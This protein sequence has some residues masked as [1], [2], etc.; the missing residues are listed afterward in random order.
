M[1][2]RILLPILVLALVATEA[3]GAHPARAATAT[4]RPASPPATR[5][6]PGHGLAVR[7]ARPAGESVPAWRPAA[8][9]WPAAGSAQAVAP[10]GS[11]A[12]SGAPAGAAPRSGGSSG[13]AAPAGQRTAVAWPGGLPMTLPVPATAGPVR[14]DV[15]DQRA[16]ARAGITGVLLRLSSVPAGSLSVDYGAFADAVG[17]DWSARLGLV[18]LPD[19]AV[20]TPPAAG[21][22]AATP[23]RSRNDVRT[24]RVTAQTGTTGGVFALTAST[25]GGTGTYGA[26]ALS[27]SSTWQVGQQSG[28]FDWSYPM[29]TVDVPDGDGPGVTLTYSSQSV[30][31]RTAETNNQTSWAGEGFDLVSGYVERRYK[32]C[33]DDGGPS[34]NGDQCWAG[35]NA[36]LVLGSTSTELVRDDATGRWRLKD[37]DGSRVEKLTGATNGD[38]DGEYW[39]VTTTDGTQYTF[40]LNHLPGWV[41][42]KPTTASAWTMP[43]Y[44]NSSGE[45]CSSSAG[46][47][48]SWCMQAWRWNL[49]YTV[50]PHGNATTYTYV[51]ETN[52]YRR[53]YDSAAGS[54]GTMTQYTRG[55][56]LKE[57][58]YALRSDAVYTA[59]PMAK[60][61][62]G[63]NERCISS[64]TF[65]CESSANFTKTNAS[66][67]PDVPFDQYC[68]SSDACTT[69]IAPSFWSRKRLTKVS[70]QV[71]SA[72]SYSTVDI[73]TLAQSFPAP[74]DG[75]TPAL[76][77]DSVTHTGNVGGSLAV[78]RVVFGKTQLANRVDT[79]GDHL[80][81]FDKFRVGTV[82]TETGEH[83][84]VT[85][86][87]P[88][89]TPTD[90]PTPQTN[91]RRCYPVYWAGDPAQPTPFLDWFH[92]YVVTQVVES[93]LTG[94]APD[95]VTTY[96]YSRGTPAW[97]FDDGE[98][99][100]K[101]KYKTWGQWRGFNRVSVVTGVSGQ[102]RSQTDYLYYQGMDGDRSDPSDPTRT[103]TVTLT[104]S[105]GVTVTDSGPLQG[106]T[107]E[108]TTLNGPGGAAVS[109]EITTPWLL[110]T[111]KRV[112]SWG[113]TTANL[114]DTATKVNRTALSSGGWRTTRV[115]TGYDGN[116]L[117][118]QVND[119]GDT[120]VSND[121]T[122]ARTTFAQNTAAWM[123]NFPART[124]VVAVACTATPN[125]PAD[126]VSDN[127]IMYDGQAYGVAPTRGDAT[128]T[129][130]LASY[131]AGTP[132]YIATATTGYD[133]YGRVTQ[134][135]DA[136]G[137]KTT[138]AYTP[139]TG[140]VASAVT[141]TNNLGHAATTDLA[142]AWGSPVD[143]VDANGARTDLSYDP[144]GRVTQV[145]LPGRAEASFPSTPN[146]SFAYQIGGTTRP[147]A[148]TTSKLVPTGGYATSVQIYDGL[149]RE[150]QT[151]VQAPGGG[152]VL[153]DTFYDSRGLAARS[154]D[155]YYNGDSAPSTAIFVPTAAVPGQTVT[156]FDGV[157]RPVSASF[158]QNG[159]LRW[160]TTTSY[161]GDRTSV[162]PP[163]GGTATT[164]VTDARGRTR[165]LMQ[166]HGGVPGG[167]ADTTSYTYTPDGQL[168]TVTDPA[169][170][171][172]RNTYDLRGRR[173]QV[174]DPD[175]GRSTHTYNDGDEL[176]SSTDARGTT[177]AYTYDGLGRK[178]AMYAGSTAG[179][180]LA[181]WDYDT[182][183]K[184]QLTR[185]TRFVNGLAYTEEVT[186]YD[187]QYHATGTKVTV[188]TD[189][190][191]ST[192]QQALAGT[193]T[194][195]ASYNITTDGSPHSMTYPGAGGLAGE[196]LTL[197]YNEV[198]DPTQLGGLVSYVSG[199]TYS[200]LGLVLQRSMSDGNGH[201]VVRNS[202]YEDG[203]DRL[204]RTLDQRTTAPNTINDTHYDYADAGAVQSIVTAQ[205]DGITD[206]QCYRYDY[207]QRLVDAWTPQ[208]DCA[209]APAS[210]SLGGPAPYWQSFGYDVAGN[211]TGET[212]HATA[213][214]GTDLVHSYAYPAAGT[215][216]PHTLRTVSG[217]PSTD[218]YAYDAAGNT[219]GRTVS[220]A[221]QTL[222]WNTEGDLATVTAGGG[223]TSYLYDA[224]GNQLIAADPAGAT[225]YLAGM[226]VH[227]STSGAKTATRYYTFAGDTVAARTNA[228]LAFLLT[229]HQNTAQ[230]EVAADAT[231][232]LTRR[233]YTP[234]GAA[235][236][237]VPATWP[238]QRG[239]VGGVTSTATGLSTLGVRQYDPV[240][241]RFVSADEVFDPDD[242]QQLNGYSYAGSDPVTFSDPSGLTRCDVG[243]CPTP[244]QN[245]HGPNYC[246]T[247]NCHKS[248]SPYNG[249][250]WADPDVNPYSGGPGRQ[251]NRRKYNRV[252][253]YLRR[254][255]ALAA[256][257]ERQAR[258]ARLYREAQARAEAAAAQRAA[259]VQA[260]AQRNKHR[261]WWQ[262]AGS[263]WDEH[264]GAVLSSISFAAGILAFTPC[265]GFCAGVA[266]VAG[267]FNARYEMR[268]GDYVGAGLD[269]LGA[270][271][272]GTGRYLKYAKDVANDGYVAL[273]GRQGAKRMRHRLGRQLGVAQRRQVTHDNFDKSVSITGLMY[274]GKGFYDR[275]RND[276]W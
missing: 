233:Y 203:T 29:R 76:W 188:P 111:A 259:A 25:S 205:G 180:K 91:T 154:N 94:G 143:T 15:F 131:S 89:C 106:F 212:D 273:I 197:T 167:A 43:V 268:E 226:E 242:P 157:G 202:T 93:D 221:A 250:A 67:W 146:L 183:A 198:G 128:R 219:T 126:V 32:A 26:S 211:R 92:R 13:A 261:H 22:T 244:W 270:A 108:E 254:H 45:P 71:L 16:S 75:T 239:F 112:R 223:T 107:R 225:L 5:S 2:R 159:N 63:V 57:I 172:W 170:N 35:D 231:Q 206:T 98:G 160:Q 276:D 78:P 17:G 27:P 195:L 238:G 149:L 153:T 79:V 129:E 72:G 152:R 267:Y 184:G 142:V 58:D 213:S 6:V 40:G 48:S 73:W 236:G 162:T 61:L 87:A 178:T 217:G 110:Q 246:E 74:G 194:S 81:Q 41:S 21:C 141:V 151:Q 187:V 39:R 103:K 166:Y 4:W 252:S 237:A 20:T 53:G 175:T 114:T 229:N 169:G 24:H 68:T 199:T 193:Y 113:T 171:V 235:R 77:L 51:P 220:G 230:T 204:L 182:V 192:A 165:Q 82:D 186:G 59:S 33:S 185:S 42:G 163:A 55:G 263:W 36:T 86:S 245:T 256:A 173:I 210:G 269:L 216:Q 18:R 50:D 69:N 139:A 3:V 161:G 241:G 181:Q 218:S 8:T 11:A 119:L 208:T 272:F 274:T 158:Y 271:S 228:G 100:V 148:V 64:S 249:P 136:L 116:G 133:I 127:R 121:E 200:K 247:H 54:S 14:V 70:T 90:K 31:G 88:D 62:F 122:C 240:T 155:E 12:P 140:G 275:F 65:D 101:D 260:A 253:D 99:M 135:T 46:F 19:C 115:D 109:G 266:A 215:A 102:P 168:A 227:A 117:V 177:L 189:P 145:W 97:H 144:L 222:T 49:D 7:A 251:Y 156:A 84:T 125:R 104:D 150:R 52:Y 134:A 191:T 258:L 123:L 1:M 257:L 243:A 224:D 28:D 10:A 34:T 138:T 264:H 174:D 196:T 262:K 207:A 132:V 44:G 118:T 83:V 179:T 56:Y 80:A 248:G 255:N 105:T 120:A 124:E 30:D 234:F 66:H 23:V 176:V 232:A 265:A 209:G 147:T 201:L 130:E 95:R 37:D 38:N 137:R 9:A 96:D 85:Y 60:V 214:G 47:A 190:S 164:T